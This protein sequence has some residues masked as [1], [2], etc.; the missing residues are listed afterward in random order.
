MLAY[1]ILLRYTPNDLMLATTETQLERMELETV[2]ASGIFD[3]APGL[4]QV[5]K[6][7]C[8]KHF[9]GTSDRI[10]EY[11][12]AVEALGRTPDFDQKKDSIVRVQFHRLRE[13]LAEYYATEGANHAIWIEIRQG[14][15]APTFVR[16]DAGILQAAPLEAADSVEPAGPSGPHGPATI[17]PH[18]ESSWGKAILVAGL[19]VA[20]ALGAAAL[21]GNK[22]HVVIPPK[23]IVPVAGPT[24]TVRILAGLADGE[25]VDGFGR[26]WQSDRYFEGGTVV[27]LP[28]RPVLGT[29]EPR[30]FES[31]RQGSFRY[32][33]PLKPGVYEM[34]LYFAETH[35]G[36]GGMAGFGGEG[37]RSFR[38]V[39]NGETV[40]RYFDVIG[41]VG[42]NYADVKLFKDISPAEDGKLH[43]SFATIATSPFINAIEITPGT[44]GRIRPIRIVASDRAYTDPQGN[45]WQP[46]R[47]AVGGQMVKRT[48]AIS[49][50]VDPGLFSWERFG[51]L[52]Y[53]L[54][55]PEGRYTLKLYFSEQW[56]GP[57][58]PGGG[59]VGSRVFDILCNGVAL[60]RDYDVFKRAGGA[61]RAYVETFRGL[62]PNHQGKIALSLVPAKNYAILSALELID[63]SR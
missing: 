26:T 27:T 40:V 60:A 44:P 29:R 41:E 33:I 45:V 7:V 16:R 4:A 19:L 48:G 51:N 53:Q 3:R 25:Y 24:E 1:S 5:L 56:L 55:V 62:Q 57:G 50:A 15:Y 10:K 17:A 18:R 63:E 39:V 61:N 43:L 13:R 31:R 58:M 34:R 32:D 20:A 28:N 23:S 42:S 46:D 12:V 22:S 11:N 38:I 47:Y 59:G 36:E 49:G 30:L 9:E 54:P 21:R 52:T 37:S 8:A 2:L 35:F 6:Y 14:Q